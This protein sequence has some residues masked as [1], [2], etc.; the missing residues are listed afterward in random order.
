[1]FFPINI[2]ILLF[3]FAGIIVL[4]VFLS[5]KENKWF[6][7][8]LPFICFAYSLIMAAGMTNWG[9]FGTL[10]STF[11]ISNMPTFILLV[12]YF[13][14][15]EKIKRNKELEKMNVQDLE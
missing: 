7:L 1:M 3:I 2:I 9:H 4:Q 13:T 10:I 14:C 15:R 8:I 11:L 6:G 5:R 12:I